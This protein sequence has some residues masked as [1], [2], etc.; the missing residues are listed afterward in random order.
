LRN[1]FEWAVRILGVQHDVTERSGPLFQDHAVA[2]LRGQV[3]REA[4]TR[5]GDARFAE[6]F[7]AGRTCSIDEL[8]DDIDR[9]T[10]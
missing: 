3:E 7:A 6:V 5:L 2:D 10:E 9:A 8:L 1:D 4:R